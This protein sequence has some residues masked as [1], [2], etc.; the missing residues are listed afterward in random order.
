MGEQEDGVRHVTRKCK[1]HFGGEEED[2]RE[3]TQ[4]DERGQ[5]GGDDY[6]IKI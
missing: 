4:E 3:G 1:G 6:F 2:Q 5:W